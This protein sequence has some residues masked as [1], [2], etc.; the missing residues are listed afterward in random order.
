MLLKSGGGKVMGKCDLEALAV[1]VLSS[2][3]RR[4]CFALPVNFFL[5]RVKRGAQSLRKRLDIS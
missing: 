4:R 3:R 2:C 1:Y 5:L